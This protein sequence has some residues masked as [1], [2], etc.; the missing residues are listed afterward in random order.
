MNEI[1]ERNTLNR[2]NLTRWLARKDVCTSLRDS[3][4]ENLKTLES[5]KDK[6]AGKGVTR[7][8]AVRILLNKEKLEIESMVCFFGKNQQRER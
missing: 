4:H 6:C 8:D 1:G 5:I 2:V 3:W 7:Q